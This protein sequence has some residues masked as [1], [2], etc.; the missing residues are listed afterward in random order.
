MQWL[1][2]GAVKKLQM[3]PFSWKREKK[4]V[5]PDQNNC[6]S[7][8]IILAPLIPVIS[9]SVKRLLKCQSRIQEMKQAALRLGWVSPASSVLWGAAMTPSEAW[10]T[11]LKVSQVKTMN[12]VLKS[13]FRCVKVKY[14]RVRACQL[15]LPHGIPWQQAAQF[16]ASF[17]ALC[18]F[19]PTRLENL[20][21]YQVQIQITF[22]FT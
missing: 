5:L 9:A 4:R 2:T 11:C 21:L 13:D 19:L 8:T 3:F 22:F 10:K 15:L 16:R 7:D 6:P 17:L 12:N 14:V 1:Y 20:R 18:H